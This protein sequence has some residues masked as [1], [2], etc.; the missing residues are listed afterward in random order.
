MFMCS[1]KWSSVINSIYS[2]QQVFSYTL[3]LFR[4]M[5]VYSVQSDLV[6]WV[7]LN[8]YSECVAILSVLAPFSE[9]QL[10]K[11]WCWSPLSFLHCKKFPEFAE[12]FANTN[13]YQ[14]RRDLFPL[15][16]TIK[17]FSRC[18]KLVRLSVSQFNPSQIFVCEAES[19]TP[20]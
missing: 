10:W 7:K 18:N 6:T 11:F 20:K 8:V 19:L 9:W 16:C 14:W 3:L 12:K 17:T 5:S 2:G 13:F 1:T 15:A 4:S